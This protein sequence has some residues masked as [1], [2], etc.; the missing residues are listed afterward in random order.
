ME[1]VNPFTSLHV[2]FF[3]SSSELTKHTVTEVYLHFL[4]VIRNEKLIRNDILLV[5]LI[6]FEDIYS[7][8]SLMVTFGHAG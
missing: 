4:I 3:P 8:L 5:N 6:F 7:V 1:A 2:S